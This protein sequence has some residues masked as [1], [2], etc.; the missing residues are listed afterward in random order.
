LPFALRPLPFAL[1]PLAG[2]VLFAVQRARA[3]DAPPARHGAVLALLLRFAWERAPA[4]V[5]LGGD[6]RR[7]AAA[8]DFVRVQ[9]PE[10][11]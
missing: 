5:G 10:T 6:A 9:A 2:G 7:L 3:G 4:D 1:R 8:V 11:P